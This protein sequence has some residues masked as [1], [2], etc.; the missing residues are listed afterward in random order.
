MKTSQMETL[1]LEQDR[2]LENIKKV[3]KTKEY[4]SIPT[5]ILAYLRNDINLQDG[6][7][8][9]WMT[10][11]ELAYFEEKWTISISLRSL[12]EAL[13]NRSIRTIQRWIT[14]LSNGQYIKKVV[15]ENGEIT[16]YAV[17]FPQ[18]IVEKILIFIKW[19]SFYLLFNKLLYLLNYLTKVSNIG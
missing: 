11:F 19:Y 3:L 14:Q 4:R 8:L 12:S 17:R 7:V 13:G 5:S 6:A 16:R 2:N 15:Q 10:L 18:E 9:C 1:N